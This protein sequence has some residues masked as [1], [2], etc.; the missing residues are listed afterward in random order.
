MINDASK[1][2]RNYVV[3]RCGEY[4]FQVEYEDYKCSVKLNEKYGECEMWQVSGIP[5][6]HAAACI[7]TVRAQ[8]DD[9]CYPFFS[10]DCWRKCYTCVIH[11]IPSMNLWPPFENSELQPP[12]A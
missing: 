8:V 5:C 1:K 11:P 10:I 6:L 3:R 9:Y 4:E 2:S 12:V 7:N